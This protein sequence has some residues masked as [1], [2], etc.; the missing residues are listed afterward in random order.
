MDFLCLPSGWKDLVLLA[1]QHQRNRGYL[2][3]IPTPDRPDLVYS[4]T[5]PEYDLAPWQAGQSGIPERGALPRCGSCIGH[6]QSRFVP[7]LILGGPAKH[8]DLAANRAGD[9]PT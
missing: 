2:L 8:F 3:R 1:L 5:Y 4:E 6:G 9:Q 7:Q